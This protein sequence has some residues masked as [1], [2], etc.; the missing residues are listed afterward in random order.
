MYAQ[1]H[2]AQQRAQDVA[3]PKPARGPRPGTRPPGSEALLSLQ[4]TA[5]NAAVVRAVTPMVQR[6]AVTDPRSR[7]PVETSRLTPEERVQLA[8]QLLRAKK[9][10]E[11]DRLRAA[12]PD[13]RDSL[14]ERALRAIMPRYRDVHAESEGESESEDPNVFYRTLRPEELPL[15]NGLRPPV[16]HDPSKSAADHIRAGSR[17]KVKSSW[18]SFTRSLKTAAA[19]AAENESR[20]AK[21]KLP[22]G[23]RVEDGRVYDT[24]DP[25]QLAAVFGGNGGSAENFAKASQEVV[26]KGGLGAEA[27]LEVFKAKYLSPEEY[28]QHKT[29]PTTDSGLYAVVRTRAKVTENKQKLRPKPI[30]IYNHQETALAAPKRKDRDDSPENDERRNRA[31]ITS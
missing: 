1:G 24:T 26:V 6:V 15:R 21:V 11:L 12:H 23:A 28:E 18:V 4:R 20:I 31:R 16:G 5:G 19:W 2:R 17:A 25:E 9:T 8:A 29:A 7:Q 27:V 10:K 22:A 3:R 30:G 13:E 14:S